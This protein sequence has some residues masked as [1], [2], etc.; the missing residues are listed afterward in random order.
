MYLGLQVN[1]EVKYISRISAEICN[2]RFT[3]NLKST[4]SKISFLCRF[5]FAMTERIM[6]F[7]MGNECDGT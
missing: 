4:I 1:C 5:N 3:M 6:A 7:V 2:L